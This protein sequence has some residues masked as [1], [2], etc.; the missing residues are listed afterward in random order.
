MSTIISP[1]NSYLSSSLSGSVFFDCTNAAQLSFGGFKPY[2]IEAWIKPSSVSGTRTIISRFNGG[3]TA[4]YGLWIQDGV[5]QSYRNV[6]PWTLNSRAILTAGEWY[7]VATTYDGATLS[8]YI[9]GTLDSS[10]AFTSQPDSPSNTFIGMRL[11]GNTP[12][13]FFAGEIYEV[14]VWN[15]CR[16]ASDI[17]ANVSEVEPDSPG[18][19][20]DYAL[21]EMPVCD[22]SYNSMPIN[23]VNNPGFVMETAALVLGGADYVDCGADPTLSFGGF[24]EYTFEGW[25]NLGASNA[26]GTILAR[27]NGGVAAEYML[28]VDNGVLSSYRN[29]VPWVCNSNTI[30]QPNQWYHVA[31][32][33][34]GQT[35]KVYI[36]GV[37]DNQCAFTSQP[38]CPD[39]NTLIGAHYD[40]GNVMAFFKGSIQNLRVWKFALDAADIQAAM[41]EPVTVGIGLAANCDFSLAPP[42]DLTGNISMMPTAGA[43]IQEITAPI[44]AAPAVMLRLEAPP[45]DVVS[46]LQGPGGATLSE[47]FLAGL[48]EHAARSIPTHVG[49]ERRA[50]MMADYKTMLDKVVA[51]AKTDPS[52]AGPHCEFEHDGEQYHFHYYRDGVHKQTFSVTSQKIDPVIEWLFSFVFTLIS[53]FFDIILSI[54]FNTTA[55]GYIWNRM[56]KN[57]STMQIVKAC[58]AAGG[59][60]ASILAVIDKMYNTG[61][62]KM[63]LS[64]VMTWWNLVSV[65][66]SLVTWLNPSYKGYEL[67]YKITVLAAKLHMMAAQIPHARGEGEPKSAPA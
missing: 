56:T 27:L 43:V 65:M 26:G 46:G 37:L 64:M 48:V 45:V 8:I 40:H 5:L 34:D 41:L 4:E 20:A 53:G 62:L 49:A 15:V 32:T 16:S 38:A 36:N 6:G 30:L 18:L 19:V 23:P 22:V 13:D 47:E 61:L 39:L 66:W 42:S 31:T 2:T 57:A 55:F 17:L 44:N 9:N 21:W 25:I 54:Q 14:R 51:S 29:V 10:T 35:L 50:A 1:L 63:A 11:N 12:A 52:N 28:Y 60:V 59:T 7:H 58:V 24:A 67:T 3:I 33:Y